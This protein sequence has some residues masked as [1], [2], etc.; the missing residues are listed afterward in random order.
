MSARATGKVLADDQ[1]GEVGR[2]ELLGARVV[3]LEPPSFA[4]VASF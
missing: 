4:F 1:A 2:Q 3:A